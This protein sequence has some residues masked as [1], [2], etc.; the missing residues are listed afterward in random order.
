MVW[1]CHGCQRYWGHCRKACPL[2]NTRLL[3][4]MLLRRKVTELGARKLM[5]HFLWK[6]ASVRLVPRGSLCY[7]GT[8]RNCRCNACREPPPV[9]HR[10]DRIL[11]RLARKQGRGRAVASRWV[12]LLSGKV[13]LQADDGILHG[14]LIAAGCGRGPHVALLRT[15]VPNLLGS[16]VREWVWRWLVAV[17]LEYVKDRSDFRSLLGTAASVVLNINIW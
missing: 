2:C 6:R 3:V 1:R 4:R 17:F 15:R 16:R 10:D 11:G 13:A 5:L 8:P 14:M 7:F 12:H 9:G